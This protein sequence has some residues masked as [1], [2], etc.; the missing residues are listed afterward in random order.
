[1]YDWVGINLNFII[2]T[3]MFYHL[4]YQVGCIPQKLICKL[5]PKISTIPNNMV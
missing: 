4:L 3:Y 1:M 5:I 2:Y